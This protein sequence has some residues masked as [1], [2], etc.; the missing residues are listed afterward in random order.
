[1]IT[2]VTHFLITQRTYCLSYQESERVK[3]N[4]STVSTL[5][6]DQLKAR[7]KEGIANKGE[8]RAETK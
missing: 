4:I 8:G 1:M 7:S 6:S 5:L 3:T 2:W